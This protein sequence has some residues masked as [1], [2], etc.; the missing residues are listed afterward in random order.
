MTKISCTPF[1]KSLN[2]PEKGNELKVISGF[3]GQEVVLN[4]SI[5]IYKLL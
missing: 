1:K 2:D 4:D 5:K 3:N